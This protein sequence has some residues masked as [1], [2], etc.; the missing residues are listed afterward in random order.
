MRVEK[1][2]AIRY[3]AIMTTK[4]FAKPKLSIMKPPTAG[5]T[6]LARDGIIEENKL[7]IRARV[8]DSPNL[9]WR[10]LKLG[11]KVAIPRP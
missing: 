2:K 5:P 6:M 10:R 7:T 1:R 3:K 9:N 8:F 4:S 11:Q